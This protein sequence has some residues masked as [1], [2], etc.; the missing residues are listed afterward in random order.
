LIIFFSLEKRKI[1]IVFLYDTGTLLCPYC[2]LPKGFCIL[3]VAV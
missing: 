3:Q 2:Y 1:F